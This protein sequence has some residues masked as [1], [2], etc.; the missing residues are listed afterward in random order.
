MSHLLPRG[1]ITT[2][3]PL[4]AW[5]I[6]CEGEGENMSTWQSS[7]REKMAWGKPKDSWSL[8]LED[9][10]KPGP[11]EPGWRRYQLGRAFAR[12][13]CSHCSRRWASAQVMILF[14]MRLEGRQG[15]VKMRFFGQKCKNCYGAKYEKPTFSQ[16]NTERILDNLMQK[17]LEKCYQEFKANPHLV[18]LIVEEE[19][20]GPHDTARCEVCALGIC[21]PQTQPCSSTS[22]FVISTSQMAASQSRHL[23]WRGAE[24]KKNWTLLCYVLLVL[25]AL[26]VLAE[27]WSGK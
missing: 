22:H 10:L 3:G 27:L 24:N 5:W 25:A 21:Y 12:F 13:K 9:N 18:D 2:S 14:H 20:E 19:V 1:S 4:S 15:Q 17:I 23:A 8:S 16:E 7:F 26:L 6:G 11:R